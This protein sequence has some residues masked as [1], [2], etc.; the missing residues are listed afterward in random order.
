MYYGCTYSGQNKRT[1][2]STQESEPTDI[3]G[4]TVAEVNTQMGI[5]IQTEG[6]KF[7]Q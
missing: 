1:R 3:K 2:W 5:K 4:G 7:P 6:H